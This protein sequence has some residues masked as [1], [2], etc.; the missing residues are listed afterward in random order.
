[1]VRG[2]AGVF[3]ESYNSTKHN[4][5]VNLTSPGGASWTPR[6]K[7][8]RSVE[9]GEAP[10]E[11]RGRG[12][13]DGFLFSNVGSGKKRRRCREWERDNGGS[14]PRAMRRA[15]RRGKE[16][17]RDRRSGRIRF[18]ASPI[19]LQSSATTHR[20][21]LPPRNGEDVQIALMV[22]QRE[23]PCSLRQVLI[24]FPASCVSPSPPSQTRRRR[25]LPETR[26][27]NDVVNLRFRVKGALLVVQGLCMLM[28]QCR[29]YYA[30]LRLRA[31]DS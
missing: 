8:R 19:I 16:R 18:G 10:G 28:R 31:E 20:H 12:T 4:P 21:F 1:M 9:K 14:G 7:K 25:L 15:R 11:R 13:E 23:K 29:Y 22:D 30:K 26:S 2:R 24:F 6:G 5:R 27:V 17:E 3:L